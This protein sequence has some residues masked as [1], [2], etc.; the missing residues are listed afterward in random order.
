MSETTPEKRIVY[1]VEEG[2][3]REEILCTTYQ[4][5]NF[6]KQLRDGFFD[7][8]DVMNYIQ[9]HQITRWAKEGGA[10]IDVCCGRG[11]MLPLLRYYAKG[12]SS[13]WGVDI[14][15]KNAEFLKGKRITDGK[16]VEDEYYPFPVN[17]IH[18]NAAEMHSK[19][20]STFEGAELLIY[21][22]AIEHMHPEAGMAS[23]HECRKLAKPGATLILTCPNTP[24][25][26]SG[27]DTRYR[28]HVYEWKRTELIEGLEAAGFEIVSEW[29][30]NI[31]KKALQ[32]KDAPLGDA[33]LK[34][35]EHIPQEWALPVI[36]S[37]YPEE[38]DEIAFRA[39]AK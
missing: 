34:I 20:P 11:L 37:L 13:Y 21:T 5:R 14:E 22:S 19:F 3:N 9:H 30:L 39:V 15:P 18:S 16:P 17:F 6:F 25:G 8:L 29:G 33:W 31:S 23:L 10:V 1:R 2:M 24:E 7:T 4:M 32:G 12:I 28:A 26:Q 36:A 27:Y 35:L 38:S